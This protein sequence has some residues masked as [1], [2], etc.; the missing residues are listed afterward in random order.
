M[1]HREEQK[2]RQTGKKWQQ[3]PW[4]CRGLVPRSPTDTGGWGHPEMMIHD[5]QTAGPQTHDSPP[6][7]TGATESHLEA[8]PAVVLASH[9]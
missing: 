1:I 2:E 4:L 8:P 5:T 7:G 9:M 6:E 3:V